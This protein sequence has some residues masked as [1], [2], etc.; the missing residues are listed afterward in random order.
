MI[1]RPP[2]STL[3]PYTTLF[4]SSLATAA[5]VEDEEV[6]EDGAI[7]FGNNPQEIPLYLPRVSLFG[8]AE[9]V[10]DAPDVGVHDDAL[11]RAEGVAQDHVGRLASDPGEGNE[12]GHGARDL[13]PMPLEEGA[14]HAL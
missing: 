4:R 10:R 5:A 6:G 2:R 1:R 14:G 8:E 13:T 12:L 11:V 3:F 7:L 9:P